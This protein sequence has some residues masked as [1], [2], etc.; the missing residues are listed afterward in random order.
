MGEMEGDVT[1]H[2]VGLVIK[3]EDE[4]LDVRLDT[5]ETEGCLFNLFGGSSP[6]NGGKD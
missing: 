5:D 2:N 4:Q 6:C 3:D 1:C